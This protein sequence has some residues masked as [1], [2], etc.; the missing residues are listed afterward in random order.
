MKC[1]EALAMAR[2][3][4]DPEEGTQPGSS[5]HKASERRSL[6][7][8]DWK[9]VMAFVLLSEMLLVRMDG[10]WVVGEPSVQVA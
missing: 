10:V 2:R 3:T 6:F 5:T 4:S 9:E 1:S 7:V 8:V